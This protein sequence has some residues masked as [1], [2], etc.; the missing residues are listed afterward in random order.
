L[1]SLSSLSGLKALQV[2]LRDLMLRQVGQLG[3]LDLLKHVLLNDLSLSLQVSLRL[4]V[5]N[6]LGN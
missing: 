6:L 4:G 3:F 2:L 1:G 5:T